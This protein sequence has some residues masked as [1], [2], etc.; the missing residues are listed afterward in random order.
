MAAQVVMNEE[1]AEEID[2]I[3]TALGDFQ[4]F[5]Y[6]IKPKPKRLFHVL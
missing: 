4:L 5:I 6:T 1:R 3:L 2:I